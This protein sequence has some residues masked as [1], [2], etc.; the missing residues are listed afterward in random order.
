MFEP[1]SYLI[2]GLV[3]GSIYALFGAG[4]ALIYGVTDLANFAQGSFLMIGAYITYFAFNLVTHEPLSSI[5]ISFSFVFLFG[6]I[7][8]TLMLRP[9]R[10]RAENWLVSAFIVTTGIMLILD[11]FAFLMWGGIYRN[12]REYYPG[13]LSIPGFMNLSFD[14][15]FIFTSSVIIFLFLNI[16]LYKTKLGRAIRAVAL[17]KNAAALMGINVNRIYAIAFGIGVGLAAI[18]GGLILPIQSIYHKVGDETLTA[19][20]SVVI[21]GGC[22]SIKGALIGGLILGVTEAFVTGYIGAGLAKIAFFILIITI[23]VF[24]PTGLFGERPA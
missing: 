23:L 9:L 12:I 10:A 24:K 13:I 16:F 20:F 2:Y 6:V 19:A 7:S 18:A 4:V 3:L 11:D 15:I 5:L 8:E 17:N 22:G 1:L 21:L 14:R